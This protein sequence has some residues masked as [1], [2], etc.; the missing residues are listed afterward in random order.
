MKKLIVKG[1]VG[2]VLLALAVLF[3]GISFAHAASNGQISGTLLDGSNKNAPLANQSVTLQMAQENSSHDVKTLKTDSAGHY[4]FTG[5]DT[6]Q[7]I[8]YAL[9]AQYQGAQYV[10]NPITL[11]T[12][13]SQNVDLQVYEATQ[14]TK[15][16]A[17]SPATILMEQP[18]T[19]RGTITIS[20]VFAFQNLANKT[21]VGSLNASKGKP[22]ALLFSLPNGIRN[23]TLGN[24]FNGYQVIQVNNGF[25][26]NAALLP[27]ANEFSF[28][29]E[30]PYSSQS[31]VFNYVTQY[32]TVQINF[33]IDPT[34]HATSGAL[35]SVGMINTNAH[36]YHSFKT[37]TGLAANTS[38]N[39][40]LDGLPTPQSQSSNAPSLNSTPTW[41]IAILIV[42][43]AIIGLTWF[44]YRS[45]RKARTSR[46]ATAPVKK[47]KTDK[48]S[49]TNNIDSVSENNQKE[50]EH[51]T[52]SQTDGD[53]QQQMLLEELL[54]LDKAYEAGQLEK[55][56][57]EKQ[58]SQTKARLRTLIRE[59]EATRK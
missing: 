5:L 57:Y 8:T 34:L 48:V 45:Q 46:V 15:D 59:Q 50:E 37:N 21:Y 41:L 25:A 6:D 24:G 51:A 33:L 4:A 1:I 38:I 2:V 16:V 31:Y 22:N 55:A 14:S 44:L 27:G 26:T 47:S 54:K 39:V 28:S 49:E 40:T 13:N 53:K 32:P 20:E 42:M 36:T 58:R 52:E 56:T 43:I 12:K 7:T 18:D 17:V 3:Q 19:A 10:S 9:Y 35:T 29:Y 23:V 11:N 30:I